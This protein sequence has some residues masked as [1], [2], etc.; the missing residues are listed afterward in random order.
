LIVT[1]G[2]H[3]P[4]IFSER[5]TTT[6]P[7][8]AARTHQVPLMIF[9]G[10]AGEMPLTGLI[11]AYQLP[12]IIMEQ[13]TSGR[14]CA[15]NRCY[16]SVPT[17]LRPIGDELIVIDAASGQLQTCAAGRPECVAAQEEANYWKSRIYALIGLE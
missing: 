11:P 1:L 17:W 14:F 4:V 15:E 3:P 7:S 9:D 13:L 5:K 12:E 16:R 10:A 8:H 6:Y 2:D